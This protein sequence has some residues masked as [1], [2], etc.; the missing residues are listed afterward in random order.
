M[1]QLAEVDGRTVLTLM[2]DVCDM[3]ITDAGMAL[4]RWQRPDPRR[5]GHQKQE[6]FQS[7][8]QPVAAQMVTEAT[9]DL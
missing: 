1:I 2:C 9:N 8:L 4:V 6:I 3:E 7:R 5:G